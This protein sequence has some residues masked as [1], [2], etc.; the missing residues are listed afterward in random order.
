LRA[1]LALA[2]DRGWLGSADAVGA[3]GVDVV[4][5]VVV[6]VMGMLL[7]ELKSRGVWGLPVLGLVWVGGSVSMVCLPGF[8]VAWRRRYL[9]KI[10]L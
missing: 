7:E 1:A 6:V 2:L 9:C 3:V 5:A 4:A 8:P 10:G